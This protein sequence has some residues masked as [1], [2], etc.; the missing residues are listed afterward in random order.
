MPG[1]PWRLL[2]AMYGSRQV[3]MLFQDHVAHA[4]VGLG[5]FIGVKVSPAMFY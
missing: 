1:W 2:K 4:L 5:G 3:S